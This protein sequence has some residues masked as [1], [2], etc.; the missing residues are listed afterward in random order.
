M[1]SISL[2][3][4]RQ[5]FIPANAKSYKKLVKIGFPST[6]IHEDS[7][8]VLKLLLQKHELKAKIYKWQKILREFYE[9]ISTE[10]KSIDYR[11]SEFSSK[12]LLF[13]TTKKSGRD[14]ALKD[15][16]K[17]KE[18][19]DKFFRRYGFSIEITI[20]E[21]R[22]IV[23]VSADFTWSE[24][25]PPI[26][27][28]DVPAIETKQNILQMGFHRLLVSHDKKF[29]Y[30]TLEI[31]SGDNWCRVTSSKCLLEQVTDPLPLISTLMSVYN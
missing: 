31:K 17:I 27:P 23:K 20:S 8:G 5:W 15:A 21:L 16:N 3:R 2:V 10:W 28:V 30:W 26:I 7:V 22:G 1:N 14:Y 6:R 19:I 11:D 18:R 25:R 12:R 29:F 4:Y 24:H 9:M 13:F